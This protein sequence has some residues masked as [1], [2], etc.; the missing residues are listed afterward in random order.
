[1]VVYN[2]VITVEPTPNDSISALLH[3]WGR[4][5]P[6]VP[7][8]AGVLCGHVFW[9]ARRNVPAM[10]P[11]VLLVW[12][13]IAAALDWLGHVPAMPAP[14]PLAVGFGLGA[15]LWGFEKERT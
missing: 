8:A 1:M 12:G 13:L 11:W 3:E 6:S 10:G 9:P 2:V 4:Q 15:W 7:F 14:L 5:H